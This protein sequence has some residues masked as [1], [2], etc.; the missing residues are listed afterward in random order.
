MPATATA[1]DTYKTKLKKCTHI[2][3]SQQIQYIYM[4]TYRTPV[5]PSH[6]RYELN[7][8]LRCNRPKLN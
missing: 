2:A 7:S 6:S 4:Y 5:A 3:H 1:I 8:E